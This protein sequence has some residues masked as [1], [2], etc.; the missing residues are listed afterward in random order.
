MPGLINNET[1]ARL[2]INLPTPFV[3]SIEVVNGEAGADQIRLT[4]NLYLPGD[5]GGMEPPAES[6]AALSDLYIYAGFVV[7]NTAIS[8]VLNKERYSDLCFILANYE[9][10]GNYSILAKNEEDIIQIDEIYQQISAPD[11]EYVDLSNYDEPRGINIYKYTTQISLT[12]GGTYDTFNELFDEAYESE[13]D[14]ITYKD[15]SVFCFSSIYDFGEST[16]E[17]TLSALQN[18]YFFNTFNSDIAYENV[19]VGGAIYDGIETIFKYSGTTDTY[20]GTVIQSLSGQY[21]TEDAGSGV[22]LSS[23]LSEVQVILAPFREQGGTGTGPA[24]GI[25]G[26]SPENAATVTTTA[27]G[28]TSDSISTMVAEEQVVRF[29]G[30]GSIVQQSAAGT[31]PLAHGFYGM[32]GAKASSSPSQ[33]LSNL[34]KAAAAIP[35]KSTSTTQGQLYNSL[36]GVIS[37]YN[38]DLQATPTVYPQVVRNIKVVDT[39]GQSAFADYEPSDVDPETVTDTSADPMDWDTTPD[40]I[41]GQPD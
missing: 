6:L 8:Q 4:I 32:S 26:Y 9:T 40:R 1:A 29:G 16:G 11:F 20:N 17:E 33:I 14:G 5:E 13:E 23:I 21:H 15:L 31:G 12:L 27:A 25:E 24:D 41:Y 19:F 37:K 30:A 39:R 2:G 18:Y 22:T 3:E 10:D 28:E 35:D 7:G 38:T 34:S 36:A